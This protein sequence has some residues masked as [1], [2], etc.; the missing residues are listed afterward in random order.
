[1][2]KILDNIIS[3]NE[4][5]ELIK[6]AS[7]NMH[8]ANTLGENIPN[9]R[10]ADNT[11]IFEK[12][13]LTQKI[14]KIISEKTNLPIENQ[15]EI[16]IVKYDI[17]GEYKSHHDFFHPN[18]DYYD[19]SIKT[20]GQRAYSCLFYLNDNFVGGETEFPTKKIKITPRIGRLLIWKNLYEDGSL[21]FES[22]HA[23]LPVIDGTKYIAIIWV[24]ENKF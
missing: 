14:K 21:D 19:L 13:E 24:R 22:L 16:H 4:C 8:K 18:T 10:I 9:Y 7:K 5:L 3:N 2:I 17:G 20:G 6:L 1:M 23:G 12:N 11:W 15:E